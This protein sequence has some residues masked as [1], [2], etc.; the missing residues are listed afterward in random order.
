MKRMLIVLLALGLAGC[1]ATKQ[2][3]PT[4]TTTPTP[5]PTPSPTLTSV[6]ISPNNTSVQ[7]GATVILKATALDQNGNTMT[8]I[9]FT[10]TSSLAEEVTATTATS[11]TYTATTAGIDTVVATPSNISN[12][13]VIQ[14]SAT[15]A[16]DELYSITINLPA[17]EEPNACQNDAEEGGQPFILCYIHST[18]QSQQLQFTLTAYDQYN[19]ALNPQPTWL[20]NLVPPSS[21]VLDSTNGSGPCVSEPGDN[22]PPVFSGVS[23]SPTGLLTIPA[24]PA[25]GGYAFAAWAVF[26]NYNLYGG[27][28]TTNFIEVEV[29]PPGE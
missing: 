6:T 3:S 29:F 9:G 1:N 8:G 24:A 16:V 13:D 19:N 14:G 27:D 23:V 22:C 17:T 15:L 28:T 21:W 10:F 26:P 11:V 2:V 5:T 4:P 20:N 18:Q 25:N 7:L 12:P